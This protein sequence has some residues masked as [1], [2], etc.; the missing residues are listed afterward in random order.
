MLT[1]YTVTSTADTGAAGTLRWAVGQANSNAGNGPNTINLAN[2]S[3]TIT[4][5]REPWDVPRHYPFGGDE[6]VPLR[7]AE[8]IAWRLAP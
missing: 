1:V 3:G 4:L 7:A 8:R 6:L 5:T 2:L